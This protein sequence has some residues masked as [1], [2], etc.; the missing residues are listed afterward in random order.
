MAKGPKSPIA[1]KMWFNFSANLWSGEDDWFAE[2]LEHERE[3]W[4]RISHGIRTVQHHE[5]IELLIGFL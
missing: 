1:T 3:S 4:R 5:A 2:E